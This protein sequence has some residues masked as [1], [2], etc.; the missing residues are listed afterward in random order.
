MSQFLRI[1]LPTLDGSFDIQGPSFINVHR[2]SPF[3]INSP[4]VFNVNI[5]NSLKILYTNAHCL[6]QTKLAELKILL[7]EETPDILG[8]TEVFQNIRCLSNRRFFM[9]L[10]TMICF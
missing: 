1:F 6:S 2:E 8:I 9:T 5:N 10:K 7:N 3:E 4:G